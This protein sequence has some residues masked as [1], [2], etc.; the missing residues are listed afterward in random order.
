MKFLNL[1]TLKMDQVTAQL[2]TALLLGQLGQNANAGNNNNGNNALG[3]GRGTGYG[4]GN[5]GSVGVGQDIL[6]YGQ[7]GLG[8]P[9]PIQSRRPPIEQTLVEHV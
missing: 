3:G 8:R 9:R 1:K 2:G 5:G 4:N 6:T 7:H